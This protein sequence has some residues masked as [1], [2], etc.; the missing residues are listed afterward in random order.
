MMQYH[1]RPLPPLPTLPTLLQT[2]GSRID[3]NDPI[4]NVGG[5]QAATHEIKTTR[6]LGPNED[7]HPGQQEEQNKRVAAGTPSEAGATHRKEGVEKIPTLNNDNGTLAQGYPGHQIGEVVETRM[8]PQDHFLYER[9]TRREGEEVIERAEFMA[10]YDAS[11]FMSQIL[12][13]A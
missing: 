11:Q 9:T 6:T 2:P 8:S 12:R 3:P 4:A 1:E 5:G 10:S 13:R 7:G